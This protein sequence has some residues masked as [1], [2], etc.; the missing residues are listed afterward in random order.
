MPV[1]CV[2]PSGTICAAAIPKSAAYRGTDLVGRPLEHLIGAEPSAFVRKLVELQESGYARVALELPAG[3]GLERVEAYLALVERSS[4]GADAAPR[5]ELLP[6]IVEA[7][8]LSLL[9]LNADKTIAVANARCRELLGAD[10]CELI[11]VSLS[12]IFEDPADARRFDLELRSRD[13][14]PFSS[15]LRCY[16]DASRCL[17]LIPRA[18]Y[19]GLPNPIGWV[20]WVRDPAASA[21]RGAGESSERRVRDVAH[22][23]RSPLCAVSGFARLLERDCADGL[24]ELGRGYLER[25]RAGIDR[26]QG[27]IEDLL[28][29]SSGRATLKARE[30]LMPGEVLQALYA[31]LKPQLEEREVRLRLPADPPPIYT[32][33]TRFYQ[34]MLNLIT[35]ALQH[36]GN[37]ERPLIEVEVEERED[38]R[39]IAVRDNGRGIPAR[40]HSRIFEAFE[41][42]VAGGSHR[43]TGLG[44]AIVKRVM[45]AHG[46]RVEIDSEVG[47][48]ATF[49]AIFPNPP[50]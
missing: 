42:G 5:C 22:D 14:K 18:V 6:D 15:V 29:A 36:M 19:G 4:D 8:P 33:P 37:V 47:Q 35:N 39:V 46:G 20:L 1:L 30:W 12:T 16:G 49:R 34:V 26:M 23:L 38:A 2:D 48:G 43:G 13:P 17:E 10:A 41:R 24:G 21:D 9:G 31:E 50:S 25:L 27:L 45:E 11:G 28:G 44:L 3:Q 32:D 7:A 40:H